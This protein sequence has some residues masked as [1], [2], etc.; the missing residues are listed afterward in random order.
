M[1]FSYCPDC[2]ASYVPA[3]TRPRKRLGWLSLPEM[4]HQTAY[5]WFIYIS[6]VDIVLTWFILLLGGSE[7]NILAD[8]V[9]SH[10]GLMGIITYKFC[11]VILVVVICEVVGRRR[12]KLGKNLS[13]AAICITA[14][15][16]MLSIAQLLLY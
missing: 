1:S 16:V 4:L 7:V 14:L 9:I 12:P 5:K 6:A 11:L 2:G 15:P 8:A 3:T 10:S 13:R